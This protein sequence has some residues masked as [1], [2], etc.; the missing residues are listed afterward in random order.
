MGPHPLSK[1]TAEAEHKVALPPKSTGAEVGRLS[2]D[3]SKLA[4]DTLVS[5]PLPGGEPTEVRIN[6]SKCKPNNAAAAGTKTEA[7]ESIPTANP[8]R[9]RRI[10]P[11]PSGCRANHP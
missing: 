8:P 9:N 7:T 5:S 10:P 2:C 11:P 1:S 4:N 6:D 3:P